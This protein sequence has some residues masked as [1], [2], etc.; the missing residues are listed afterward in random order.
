MKDRASTMPALYLWYFKT[1]DR[2]ICAGKTYANARIN[3][4]L[5]G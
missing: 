1:M 3:D 5:D 2:L 4:A